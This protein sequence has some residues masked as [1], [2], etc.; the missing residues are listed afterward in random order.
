MH[1]EF[2]RFE[3]KM[4]KRF[5][6]VEE[7]IGYVEQRLGHID[8]RLIKVEETLHH[9]AVDTNRRL[10]VHGDVIRRQVMHVAEK[11][12]LYTVRRRGNA[13]SSK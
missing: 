2:D 6:G 11:L 8:G 10:A 13:K 1:Q 4:N 3:I 12:P 7:R 5:H 9:H